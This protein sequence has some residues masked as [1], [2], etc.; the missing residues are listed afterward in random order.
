MVTRLESVRAFLFRSFFSAYVTGTLAFAEST[1]A[2]AATDTCLVKVQPCFF[3][4]N[5]HFYIPQVFV[6]CGGGWSCEFTVVATAKIDIW[7]GPFAVLRVF[8]PIID[9]SIAKLFAY[10]YR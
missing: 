9:G 2:Y 8:H 6:A 5:L 10:C 7:R 4:F 3:L 1:V